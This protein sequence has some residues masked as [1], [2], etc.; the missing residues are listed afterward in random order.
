[1]RH[2]FESFWLHALMVVCALAAAVTARAEP[3]P[4][5]ESPFSYL[6]REQQPE[7]IL[8]G[9]AKTFGLD[10][11][12]DAPLP[13]NL[14]AMS[15]RASAATPTE[16]LN[17]FAAAY[18]LTWY[19]H[20]G[21]LYVSRTSDRITRLIPTKGMS[22]AALKKAFMDMG[23][24][25]PRFGFGEVDERSAVMVSGPRSYV[26]RI[27]QAMSTF[28]EP[29][30]D[31]QILVFRLKHA[32]VEDRTIQY[33]DKQLV[34]P[35]VATML[36]NL[37]SEGTAGS[38]GTVIEQVDTTAPMRNALRPLAPDDTSVG[39]TASNAPAASAA[40]TAPR[41][42]AARG[43][44]GQETGRNRA[45]IQADVRLNAIIIRDRPQNAPIYRELIDMLDV[46]TSLIEIEA[47]IVDVNKSN[48]SEL[49]V[50]WNGR[51]GK[52]AG[53]FG[54]PD[55]PPDGTTLTLVRGSNVNPAT[56]I[57]DAGNFL[58]TRIK[59]MEGKGHARIVSR[60]FILTQDNMG[61]LIDLSDTFYVQ[62]TGERV[63]TVTPVSVGVTLKVTPR[64]I[65]SGGVRSVHLVVDIEDGS[66]QDVK[67]GTLPT[68]RRSTIG[69]EALVGENESL[70]IG[71]LNT[72]QDTRQKDQVPVL[73]DIPALGALFSKTVTN[74]AKS[75]RLFLITPKIVSGRFDALA[76]LASSL[77]PPQPSAAAQPLALQPTQQVTMQQPEA[78]G[79][80]LDRALGSLQ[81]RGTRP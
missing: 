77:A 70:L 80:Q 45:V 6:G 25:D 28:P 66:I 59:A 69:T 54:N 38:V 3:A 78:H 50:D 64:V 56:V 55:T 1:M 11:R 5:P 72:E 16:F 21:A 2:R 27:E 71:G 33:R 62:T 79:L 32:A 9:F 51:I 20:A 36:R 31:Q 39:S 57:A 4:W 65:V 63:A 30:A 40:A 73:G 81:P 37:L 26:Q 22:G 35:G 41:S 47:A 8:A 74:Y 17:Q 48:M 15:G 42:P 24:I 68:V 14:S 49:G 67:V 46:P 34:T 44:R 43:G 18:G 76:S 19:Y 52:V 10:L 13:D 23:L 53:G 12:L 7:K 60:P 61:A 75:E 58:M 29:Q